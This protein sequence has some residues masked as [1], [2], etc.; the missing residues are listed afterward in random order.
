MFALAIDRPLFA[1]FAPNICWLFS[2]HLL[3][4]FKKPTSCG[5]LV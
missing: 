5:W 3:L 4:D 2:T 1:L